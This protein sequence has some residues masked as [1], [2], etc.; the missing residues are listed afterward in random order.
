MVSVNSGGIIG[1]CVYDTT[2]IVFMTDFTAGYDLYVGFSVK[3]MHSKGLRTW[4]TPHLPQK[5]K[6]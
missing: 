6:G 5:V 4:I 1:E 2:G 3:S